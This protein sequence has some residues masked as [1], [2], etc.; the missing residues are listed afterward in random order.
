MHEL[1]NETIS[2]FS[3]CVTDFILPP[4]KKSVGAKSKNRIPIKIFT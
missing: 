1:S 4:H 2:K 3:N